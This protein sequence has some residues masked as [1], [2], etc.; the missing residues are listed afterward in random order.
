MPTFAPELFESSSVT[1]TTYWLFVLVLLIMWLV[2]G[3]P[4]ERR[5]SFV[6]IYTPKEYSQ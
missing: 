3:A 5:V 2:C 6:F 4:R 1:I